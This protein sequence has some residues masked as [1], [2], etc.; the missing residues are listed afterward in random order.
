LTW[1]EPTTPPEPDELE[2]SL[3]GPGFGECVVAHVGWGDWIIVDSCVAPDGKTPAGL[4]YLKDLGVE[5]AGAVKRVVAT[6]WHNDHVRGLAE[7]M[8][9]CVEAK[10]ICSQ[11]LL[12]REFIALTDLWRR[13]RLVG[14]PISELTR[15][16][17]TIA[18]SNSALKGSSGDSRLGF[19]IANRCLWRRPHGRGAGGDTSAEVHSLSPSDAAVRESLKDIAAL[20]PAGDTLTKPVSSRPNQFSVLLWLRVAGV[21]CLL[22]ADMEEQHNPHGGWRLIVESPERP[23]GEASAFKVPHHGSLTGECEAVWTGMLLSDPLALLTPFRFGRVQ[24][25]T[26]KDVSRIC[27]RTPHAFITAGFGDRSSR[28][29]TGTVNRTI[30]ETVRYI[31]KVNDSFG[32]VRARRKLNIE[33]G[34][35]SVATF[36]DAKRLSEFYAK[37]SE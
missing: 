26:P 35:W 2:I 11:A 33:S 13:Q 7:T 25:P 17:D 29:K 23:T 27:A 36:G 20:L 10:F 28:G 14:S 30:R 21:R 5:P 31:R 37:E 34:D 32:H 1:S 12:T 9:E 6:H 24:L 8:Q 15:V 4:A 19:A 16:L 3:F 18:K 22:G